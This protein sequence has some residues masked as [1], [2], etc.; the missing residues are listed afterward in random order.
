MA[1]IR[2]DYVFG[3]LNGGGVDADDTTIS[4]AALAR[5]PEVVAPDVAALTLHDPDAGQY[6]IVHVTDHA[7]ASTTATVTRGAEGSTPAIWAEGSPWVLGIT[8]EDVA[9]FATGGGSSGGGW[10][11]VENNPLTSLT[12]FTAGSGTWAASG[13]GIRQSGTGA[14]R[15]RLHLDELLALAHCMVEVVVEITALGSTTEGRA[16]LSFGTPLT[17]D[18][19]GGDLVTLA[20]NGST[21]QVARVYSERDNE[22]GGASVNLAA[23]IANGTPI[24]LR[25]V[26][27]GLDYTTYINGQILGTLRVPPNAMVQ[28]RLALFTMYADATFRDLRVWTPSLPA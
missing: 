4:S 18:G 20:S 23:T 16:G 19:S 3:T 12:G 25:I 28:G 10:S 26:R 15:C 22:A 2:A 27:A 14:T 6:E 1:R 13:S 7:A 9:E 11:E 24:T 5:L 17:S 8:Q 21:A